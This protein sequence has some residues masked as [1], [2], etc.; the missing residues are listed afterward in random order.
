[1]LPFDQDEV[2]RYGV[3][4]SALR[5]CLVRR[6]QVKTFQRADGIIFLSQHARETIV[7]MAGPLAGKT[8]TIPHGVDARFRRS[9]SEQKPI[10]EYSEQKPFRILYVSVVNLYKHQWHVV[11]AVAR[12]SEKGFPI[13]VDLVGAAWPQAMRL[14]QQAMQKHD[15]QGHFVH[16]H[17][18]LPYAELPGHYQRADAFVF[19]SSCENLPNILLEAMAAGLPIACAN[20]GPMPEVAGDAVVFFDPEEPEDIARALAQLLSDPDLRATN[21]RIASERARLYSWDRCATETFRFLHEIAA[22]A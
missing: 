22:G 11:D 18:R 5:L 4:W 20:R 17:G 15:P 7:K 13:Q 12:L 21:A 3:S 19:A 1:M 8:M 9:P 14:L 10:S 2:R 16:Y 6:A